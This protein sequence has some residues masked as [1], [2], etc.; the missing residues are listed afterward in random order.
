MTWNRNHP[1]RSPEFLSRLHDGDLSPA[2]RAHFETHRAHCAECRTSAAEYERAL[3]LFRSARSSA[4]PADMANRV[5]RKVQSVGRPRRPAI[6][7]FFSVDW[8]WAGAFAAALLVLLVA[9]PILLRQES[10]M[11]VPEEPIAIAMQDRQV[12]PPAAPP[13]RAVREEAQQRPFPDTR[14]PAAQ[15]PRSP[16]GPKDRSAPAPEGFFSNKISGSNTDGIPQVQPS[17]AKAAPEPKEEAARTN[18]RN[19]GQSQPIGRSAPQAAAAPAQT[20]EKSGGEGGREGALASADAPALERRSRIV[21]Q[22]IDGQGAAPELDT[23]PEEPDLADLR[24]RSFVLLLEA[25]GRV[26]DI[27][28]MTAKVAPDVKR[29]D[30]ALTKEKDST[31]DALRRLRFKPGERPRRLLLRVE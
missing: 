26:R 3:S 10:R 1:A 29:G 22:P 11:T 19:S 8:R 21:V 18:D 6:A 15:K 16:D 27:R 13:A 31:T 17:R 25:S 12:A 7:S 23:R 2:Q 9:A 20:Q 30:A 14:R 5:L 24:G 4:P 28:E